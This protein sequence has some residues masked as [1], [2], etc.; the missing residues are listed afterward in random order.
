MGNHNLGSPYIG[1]LVGISDDLTLQ[2]TGKGVFTKDDT[3]CW[4][5]MGYSPYLQ[6]GAENLDEVIE[7]WNWFTNNLKIS[8]SL[9]EIEIEKTSVL[10]FILFSISLA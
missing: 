2:Y 5:G 3:I 7:V 1:D 9:F 4:G 10:E 8:K 6:L